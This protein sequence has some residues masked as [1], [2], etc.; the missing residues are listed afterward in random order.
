MNSAGS[1]RPTF[2]TALAGGAALK[3][4]QRLPRN[5]RTRWIMIG[6]FIVVTAVILPKDFVRELNYELGKPW[7]A[8]ELRAD[9]DYAIYKPNAQFEEEQRLALASVPPVFVMDSTLQSRVWIAA[10]SAIERC[11]TDLVSYKQLGAGNLVA[12]NNLRERIQTK[13][14]IDAELTEVDHPDVYAW[15]VAFANRADELI[16][17]VYAAGLTDTAKSA[18]LTDLIYVRKSETHLVQK[19]LALSTSELLDFVNSSQYGTDAAERKLLETMIFPLMVPNLRYD[20]EATHREQERAVGR[21]SRVKDKVAKGEIIISKGERVNESNDRKI[22]SYLQARYDRYGQTPYLVTLGGQLVMVAIVTMLLVLFIRNN[23]PRLF[24][25][26]RKLALVLLVFLMMVAVITLVLKLTVFTQEIAGLNY[27]YLAPA[28]MVTIILSAFFDSRF[29]FFGNLIVAVF[30][31]AIIP[32]GFEYFF[33]QLCAGTAAVYSV[34]QL[35][36]RADFF[37]SL[38]L[39]FMTYMFSYLGYKFYARG[40]FAS[41]EYINLL[42]F[43][44]NVMLTFIT[45]PIIYVFE[46][47]FGITSDLTYIELLDTNHPLLKELSVRAPGTFQHSI[48]V[49]NLTEAVLNKIG[50]NSLQAKVGALFHDV[51]KMLNPLFFIENL[52]DHQNP[53]DAVTY[54]ESA[55]IIIRHVSDGVRLAQE[56]NLPSEVIDFIKTHHGT[57]RAEY[58]YR[59]HLEE[60]PGAEVDV[61]EFQ[62]PGP[63]PFTREMAV[64]MI[65]DSC[66]AAA[67]AMKDHSPEKLLALVEGVMDNKV[68]QRQF[69]KANLTFKDLEDAKQVIYSMLTSMYHGRIEYPEAEPETEHEGQGSV[70]PLTEVSE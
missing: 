45:Y 67:R 23:R 4:A 6:M 52:G 12:R 20:A 34:N 5:A 25:S 44:L 11:F 22:A 69:D 36:N 32:N 9:F 19:A 61:I 13:Y 70:P 41:I 21:V 24:F 27:I 49:A 50:G 18:L 54:Q 15:K 8:S 66:E 48:Q 51:G 38:T 3:L 2:G 64:L 59:K 28:C 60:H 55:D 17:D 62:Y 7:L 31:G 63:L 42:L 26:P 57:T 16:Q 56:H 40:S 33:V 43:G 37:I 14:G 1:K 47:I 58:F 10:A 53:H 29:A 65:A 30:A 35:R 68:R 46:R 39:I